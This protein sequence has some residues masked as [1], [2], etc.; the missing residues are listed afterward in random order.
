MKA[1]ILI[2]TTILISSI[3]YADSQQWVKPVDITGQVPESVK[4]ISSTIDE[5]TKNIVSC[6]GNGK[7]REECICKQ[8]EGHNK[9]RLLY[10][11]IVAKQ[12]DWGGRAVSY[13]VGDTQ[14]MVSFAGIKLQLQQY[15]KLCH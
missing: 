14:H 10:K 13:R 12:P 11:K 3:G 5:I 15:D 7:S 2:C 1:R 6:I 4:Q 9:L 8:K